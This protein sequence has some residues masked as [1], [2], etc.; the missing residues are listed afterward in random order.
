MGYHVE[1]VA[2]PPRPVGWEELARAGK[3]LGWDA[4]EKE[5]ELRLE[6]EGR[7]VARVALS[8]GEA[9]IKTPDDAALTAFIAL[10]ER[11]GLRARGDEF[12]SYR[13]LDDWYI[14]RDD[15]ALRARLSAPSASP[16][17]Q[18]LMR[19][20]QMINFGKLAVLV[21]MFAVFALRVWKELP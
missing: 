2:S 19:Q 16:A 5:Q 7:L 9:W 1:L 4:H 14:H 15:E 13:S 20:R 11:M 21:V 3:A 10:A 8:D 6:P 12:E 18:R 17:A